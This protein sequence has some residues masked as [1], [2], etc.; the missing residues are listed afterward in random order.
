MHTNVELRDAGKWCKAS[1]PPCCLL[2]SRAGILHRLI[3][4]LFHN[5]LILKL[6]LTF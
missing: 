2:A 3:K 4:S 6:Q 1:D 5:P